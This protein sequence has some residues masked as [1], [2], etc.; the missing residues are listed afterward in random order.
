MTSIKIN[1]DL[2]YTNRVFADVGGITLE[3]LNYLEN[4]FLDNIGFSLYV[5]KPIYD[6]YL[7]NILMK[8]SN[9]MRN[10]CI[11]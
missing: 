5:H 10:N 1:E 2:H 3:K 9:R 4:V 7:N 6:F 11:Q 8:I